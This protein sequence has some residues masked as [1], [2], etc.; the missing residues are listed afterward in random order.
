V[1]VHVAQE[2]IAIRRACY[3]GSI[4]DFL[5]ADTDSVFGEIVKTHGYSVT[6]KQLSTWHFQIA[7]LKHQ[8]VAFP[9]GFVFF[10]FAIPRVGKR[11]DVLL[12]ID[13][14]IFV[15]EYKVGMGG[16][17]SDAIKQSL[18]YA[19]DLKNFHEGSHARKIVPVLLASEAANALV[20]D[21][22]YV[23]QVA[24]P[25]RANKQTLAT[26]LQHFIDHHADAALDPLPWA[27]SIYKPTPTICEAA[28]ALY[29][30]HAV[31]DIS[32]S[33]AGAINLSRTASYID[34]IIETSKAKGRKSICFVTGVPGS[35]KT[36]AGLN[37]ATQRLRTH[38][39]EH[40]VFLSGNAPLVSVLREA[41]ARDEIERQRDLPR[42]ERLDK[43]SAYSKA[44]AFIQNIH[45]F[46]DANLGEEKPPIEKVV[47]FDEAQ[48]AWS[49]E[50]TSSFM[51]KKRGLLNFSMSEPSFLLSVMD[52]H[53]D[54][55]T[56]ICLVGGG[57][58]INTGEAGLVEW[59]DALKA[60]FAGWDVY[61]SE[62]LSKSDHFGSDDL[63]Q[64]L[65]GRSITHERDLHLSVSIRSF[66]SEKVSSFVHA[67][68][69]G[70]SAVARQVLAE[71]PD[72]PIF[73]TRDLL[74]AR[75]WL[76]TRTR[77][78]ERSGLVASSNGRRLKAWGV[79]VRVK[80]EPETWFLNEEKDVRSSYFL[81]DVATEFDIQGLELDWVGLVWDAN[82]RREGDRWGSYRFTG[83]SWKNING[84]RAQGYL[85]NAYRV[86]LTRARQGMVICVPEGDAE[87]PT[88]Q[89]EFYD[90]VY[91]YL[92]ACGLPVLV[93]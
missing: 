36:L 25:Q 76:R 17:Q 4:A 83:S 63:L 74:T 34:R 48:R 9:N 92:R 68:I 38:D 40:A 5:K 2:N 90:F 8:L 82:L 12:L 30:G 41:L 75:T 45:H 62:E 51:Q 84:D 85:R 32:R 79:D 67:L 88:R 91:D 21:R 23:D 1:A 6:D 27:A 18:N 69:D 57:Q 28:Q 80:I 65:A 77:G 72:Y 13:G 39:D 71:I 81:E 59:F 14:I 16:Y 93:N 58:E 56:V 43:E 31:E 15:V 3:Q 64:H 61:L 60:S 20:D 24:F 7:H 89:P 66:R 87:D 53:T 44:S 29:A 35:G 46:R 55:C 52:R 26:I 47:V 33:D 49:L 37:I 54:W 86:L 70:E 10:E 42:K 11:V 50:Q 73:I 19:V 22:W 78:L